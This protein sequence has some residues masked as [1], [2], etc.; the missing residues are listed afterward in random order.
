MSDLAKMSWP[1]VA[2]LDGS[3]LV[4]LL[5]IGSTEPHGPHLPLDTA[6]SIAM[7]Q[8]HRARE[9]LAEA[10]VQTLLL[11]ALPY[12]VTHFSDGFE[13]TLSI[14]PGTLW[15]LLEDIVTSLEEQGITRV[16][17]ITGHLDPAH[18]KVLRNLLLDYAQRGKEQAQVLFPD[19]EEA[20][21][22]AALGK[23]FQSGDR[24]AGQYESS[25]LLACDPA[26]VREEQRRSLPALWLD[27]QSKRSA[28]AKNYRQAGAV[29]A[30]CGDPAAA[31]A[32]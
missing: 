4:A 12:G 2:A 15:A 1:E 32:A 25:I 6:V 7:A 20:A 16:V 19:P 29:Q 13:G 24:H 5:P 10:G 17:F 18:T 9:L 21:H 8:V 31:S 26:A 23:E 11:P 14:R 22:A 27:L 3:D 28:G 30:Y